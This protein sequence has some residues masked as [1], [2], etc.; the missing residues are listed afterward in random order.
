[1]SA[2][3]GE[4]P[5]SLLMDDSHEDLSPHQARLLQDVVSKIKHVEFPTETDTTSLQRRVVV[6]V[7]FLKIG[8]I[9]TLKECFEADILLRTKWREP[10]LDKVT[11]SVRL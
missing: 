9:S 10:E 6:H 1:M 5:G 4:S 2:E 7:T 3:A 11:V 8:E